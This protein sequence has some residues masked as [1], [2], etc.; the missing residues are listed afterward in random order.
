MF[1]SFSV[2]SMITGGMFE[3]DCVL[4]F[5]RIMHRKCRNIVGCRLLFVNM[6]LMCSHMGCL[7]KHNDQSTNYERIKYV[8]RENMSFSSFILA[9]HIHTVSLVFFFSSPSSYAFFL[10]P[11]PCSSLRTQIPEGTFEN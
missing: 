5:V 1:P 9:L 11:I 2:M 4:V 6:Y 3:R 7:L 10:V 8:T